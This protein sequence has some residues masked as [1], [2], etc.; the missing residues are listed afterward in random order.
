MAEIIHEVGTSGGRDYTS[1][2]AW[3]ADQQRDLVTLIESAIAECYDDGVMI[4]NC[5][6]DGWITA[7]TQGI[8]IRTS[9]SQRHHGTPYTGFR[10]YHGTSHG[11]TIKDGNIKIDGIAFIGG[12]GSSRGIYTYITANPGWVQIANCFISKSYIGIYHSVWGSLPGTL[13]GY[14]WNNI[15]V[16]CT[17]DGIYT[18]VQS[19]DLIYSYNNVAYN[20][21]NY[22][23]NVYY[24]G[25]FVA[26]NCVVLD[27]GVKDYGWDATYY[28]ADS[29]YNASSAASGDPDKAPGPNSLYSL[30]ASDQFTS[31][32]IGAEIIHVKDTGADIYQSGTNLSADPDLWFDYD[33]Y[34]E[35]RALW[36]MGADAYSVSP[37]SPPAAAAETVHTVGTNGGLRDYTSLSAWEVDIQK[38]LTTGNSYEGET[39]IVECYNDGLMS[40]SVTIDGWNTNTRCFIK[41][42]TPS[43]QRHDGTLGTGFRLDAGAGIP[44]YV[45]DAN[46]SIEGISIKTTGFNA[47]Y[48]AINDNPG[49][50]KASY[51]II[52]GSITYNHAGGDNK[53]TDFYIWDNFILPNGGD[54]ISADESINLSYIYSNSIYGGPYGIAP[55]TAGKVIA[56]NNVVCG[57]ATG[58]YNHTA[59]FH[60]TSDYNASEDSVA[61]GNGAPGTNSIRDI[62]PANNFKDLTGGD[63]DLHGKDTS[64]DIYQTGVDLSG[65]DNLSFSDDIDGDTR[66][67]LWDIGADDAFEEVVA[68]AAN[69]IMHIIM[70]MSG[71]R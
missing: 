67:L 29:E 34:K 32:D 4:D 52:E 35:S 66:G 28:H 68:A 27:S 60:A 41:I 42:Y 55:G 20:C 59:A 40:N 11:I 33:F 44:F 39:E 57:T 1:L 48:F 16:A 50:C 51:N 30:V 13:L 65:D 15:I 62:I 2:S 43:A 64:A 19:P 10:I 7:T 69:S 26:K 17:Q 23:F 47:I 18:T 14:F 3:E 21:G 54:G 45:R 38:N 37:P 31:I 56:K 6:I 25:V 22:G 9:L 61:S 71:R 8:H 53:A 58:D 12:G 5:I 49:W 24:S 70:M 63:E 36:D 46:V